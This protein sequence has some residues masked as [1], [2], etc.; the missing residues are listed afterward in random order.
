MAG[1]VCCFYAYTGRSPEHA[2]IIEDSIR[3]IN[4]SAADVVYIRSWRT[5]DVPGQFIISKIA[6]AIDSCHV[7]MC[8]LTQP[9]FNVLF[10][11]GYAIVKNK[12]IWIT[13][14]PSLE[15]ARS[16]YK[17]LGLTSNIGYAP[18]RNSYELVSAFFEYT[19]YERTDQTLLGSL[20]PSLARLHPSTEILLYLKSPIP[21]QS[22]I[23]LSR[24]V[25]NRRLKLV[26]DDPTEITSQTLTW[27][28]QQVLLAR[29]VVVHLLDEQRARGV[30]VLQNAKYS[31]V[32]GMAHAAGKQ[33][34]MVAQS[35]FAPPIDYMH[36]LQVHDTASRLAANVSEW[37]DVIEEQY[38]E[39]KIQV[40]HY[41]RKQE[42]IAALREISLGQSIAELESEELS[43]YFIHTASYQQA[44]QTPQS[45]IF[46]GRKGTGKTAN[47]LNLQ[48]EL[49]EGHRNHICTIRPPDYELKDVLELLTSSL[50]QIDPGY[51][52][53][54]LWKF[55]IYTELARSVYSEFEKLPALDP[56]QAQL[57]GFADSHPELVT[58][59]FAVRLEHAVRHL[60]N[61][62]PVNGIAEQRT[63]VS[64]ILHANLLANLREL[65]G[66]ALA[67]KNRVVILV[68]NLDKAWERQ[69]NLETLAD[70]LFGL[71]GASR[72]ISQEFRKSG[73][74][75]RYVNLSLII[76]LRSDIFSYIQA[77]AREA[78][79]L[80]VS[81]IYW[82]D[83]SLLQ[84]IVEE[85][86]L[87]S[88]DENISPDNIW[89]R[90]F[91]ETVR[92]IP[93]LD[94]I[95]QRIIPRP[96]DIIFICKASLENALNHNHE[97]IEEVDIL[98]A[99]EQYSTHAF[100]SLLVETRDQLAGIENFLIEFVGQKAVVSKD[101]IVT[102]AQKAKITSG[103]VNSAISLLCDA[104][105]LGLETSPGHF[106]YIV[107]ESEMK[108]QVLY[109]LATNVAETTGDQRYEIHP[110]YH[111]FLELE[112]CSPNHA[113]PEPR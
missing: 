110:A 106:E 83:H 44:L 78:D 104:G 18:Y 88:L 92:G 29:A 66:K 41:H 34:L 12:R 40:D 10:E 65:L 19:P 56:Q 1:Q 48:V 30:Y 95:M 93:T 5:L 43:N 108:K 46:I 64:E 16:S 67:E 8:D 87:N 2:E 113:E 73:T 20:Q 52:N 45:M 74:T 27:Y 57:I 31:L 94:Y 38:Q 60:C 23:Q 96:R 13:L 4:A 28:L 102:F 75:W 72:A 32:A 17:Q 35:P 82:Q 69:H 89:H 85:R 101:Q 63:K 77:R 36:L 53:E 61:I 9:N 99:E 51:L 21:T 7:F 26:T 42:A 54:S 70:F 80:P 3:Q 68:D 86:F 76:F 105:F 103:E 55:L 58:A 107:D 62:G 98:Q 79:K 91:A 84:R 14:D 15:D 111:C 24:I 49:Q 71:L 109:K 11:L 39:Q 50:S 25:K 59:E 22:S 100:S 112:S 37:I 6:Q 97:R 47:L 81:Q 33:V 90:F